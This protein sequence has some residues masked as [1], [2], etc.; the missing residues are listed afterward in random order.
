MSISADT[1]LKAFPELL[2]H[3]DGDLKATATAPCAQETPLSGAIAFVADEANLLSLLKSHVSILVVNEKIAKLAKEKNTGKTLLS[4][5][6]SYL[7]MALVNARFFSLPFVR[8]AFEQKLI[9]STAV[10]AKSAT[11]AE[12]V[13]L[14]PYAVV[15]E[16]VT[17]GPGTYVGAHTVIEPHTK[18]GRDCFLHAHVYVGHSCKLGDR[19]EIKPNS[20]IGSDGYGYARDEKNNHYRIPHYGAVIIEDDVHIGASCCIDR[21]TYDPAVIGAGTKIDN[22]C[23]FGHNIRIG[24]NCL[25]TAGFMSAGSAKIGDNCVFGGRSSVNGHIEITSN[26]QFG[27]L[28]GVTG[29]ITVPG[30][31][32]GYPVIPFKDSMKSNVSLQHLPRMRKNLAKVMKHLGLTNEDQAP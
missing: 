24:K 16:N 32:A 31:Y 1:I 23:H 21:G 30:A 19:V 7:A 2:Q 13:I 5:R 3:L 12:G 18:I 11:L 29:D 15:S 14:A 8:S 17:I 20:T 28:S 6:N 4:S 10:V 25:I 27:P 9:H 22:H 26:C